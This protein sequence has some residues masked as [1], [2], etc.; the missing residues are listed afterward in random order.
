M[1]QS[2]V[3]PAG[4]PVLGARALRTLAADPACRTAF[5]E[6][7]SL[8]RTLLA[9][10]ARRYVAA[11]N[12]DEVLDCAATLRAKDYQVSVEAVGEEINDPGEVEDVVTGYLDLL[13]RSTMPLQLGFDLSA[14]G[15]LLSTELALENTA[16]VLTAAAAHGSDVVISMER[17][18]FVD[19]V[20]G[21]F[22]KLAEHHTNV[23][24]TVQAYLHRTVDDLPAIL[25]TGAKI[26]LVK[27][28]YV[29]PADI[30]L[31]RGTDLHTRYLDLA[32][33]AI[34]AGARVALATQNAALLNRAAKAGVLAGAAEIE[35]LHGVR[36]EL[37]RAHHEAGH[38][39]RVYLTYGE[40]W[41]LHLLHRLAER[42]LNVIT[43]LADLAD[44]DRVV[45]GADY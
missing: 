36:P 27:G 43:A 15:L 2:T 37:L 13:R 21:V 7:D 38:T 14:V 11:A 6:P 9:P 42:P 29:E 19:D 8:L 34:D 30:A 33:Q 41:W 5:A 45:F 44:P 20:L 32:Q 1:S 25:A 24:I 16:R 10:A 12:A 31:G 4:I 3:N 18:E 17:S 39:C 40:N 35:M 22:T 28:V 23:G 26:R